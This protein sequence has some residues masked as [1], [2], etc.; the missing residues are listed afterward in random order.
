MFY[1]NLARFVVDYLSINCVGELYAYRYKE[2]Y[3]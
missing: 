2:Y 3:R 1:A